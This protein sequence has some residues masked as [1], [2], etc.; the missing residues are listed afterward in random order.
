MTRLEYS[1]LAR[2]ASGTADRQPTYLRLSVDNDDDGDT[3]DS[4]F[5]FPANN[6]SGRERRV[7]ALGRRG[8]YDQRRR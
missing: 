1:T 3:D 2:P 8:R 6:G 5:F 4:L 7:A